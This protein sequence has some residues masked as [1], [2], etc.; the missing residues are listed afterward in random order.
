MK[1]AKVQLA[2]AQGTPPSY[3]HYTFD[4]V[5]QVNVPHHSRQVG[6]I[7]Y[8]KVCHK[9]QEYAVIATGNK[10]TTLWM[11]TTVLVP[12]VLTCKIIRTRSSNNFS[13]LGQSIGI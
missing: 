12:M 5:E 6:S 9:I 7:I 10:S 4:F 11:K 2:G 1:K 3:V 8:F 13:H